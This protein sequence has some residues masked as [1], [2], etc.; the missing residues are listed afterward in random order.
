M[1]ENSID[2]SLDEWG[3]ADTYIVW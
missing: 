2:S 1:T 3:V